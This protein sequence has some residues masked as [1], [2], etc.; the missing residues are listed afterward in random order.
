MLGDQR[1]HA[2]KGSGG[3]RTGRKGSVTSSPASRSASQKTAFFKTVP[4]VTQG[5]DAHQAAALRPP[6]PLPSR[7]R[8][9]PAA[10]IGLRADGD[11]AL[12]FDPAARLRLDARLAFCLSSLLL[13]T[14]LV[15]GRLVLIHAIPGE[16][17]LASGLLADL[18]MAT[19]LLLLA[20]LLQGL[21][22]AASAA[23]IF[24]GLLLHLA[25]LEMA[26]AMNTYV[27]L[28]DLRF[29]ADE[30]FLQGSLHL[31]FPVYSAFLAASAVLLLIASARLG[32]TGPV[33]RHALAAL[34]AAAV[35]GVHLLSGRV[36]R[37]QLA[38]MSWLSLTRSLQAMLAT[39]GT[40]PRPGQT[41]AAFA[42]GSEEG[43]PLLQ[44]TPGARRNVL[45]VVLEGIPGAYLRQVQ[46][47]AGLGGAVQMPHLSRIAER[48]LVVPNFAA[49]NRQTI[50]GLY[51]L[52]SGDYCKLSLATPKIYDYMNLPA[53]AREPCL[54]S[55]LASRGYATGYLQ[56]AELAYM[57]K[58]RFMSA[59]GFKQVLGKKYFRY[60]HV[61]FYWGPDDK[62]FF[63]QAAEFIV[64]M[65]ASSWTESG[66]IFHYPTKTI[67]NF[68]AP[69]A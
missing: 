2:D 11:S 19:C 12:D 57:S 55:T 45:I 49:H 61:P 35:L 68:H 10:S 33:P 15:V 31:S 41:M 16:R 66:K 6:R 39:A 5:R 22:L 28:P 14:V 42:A 1:A 9:P 4:I 21:H 34:L 50:R 64:P 37:W 20:R 59:A 30:R 7:C 56:A 43:Q 62:A 60:Q 46:Q 38:S 24:L 32:P 26:A 23:V 13:A 3:G 27:F 58:D 8:P 36:D 67:Q 18:A 53:Q 63:E 25:N 47:H 48:S 44:R 69:S 52:L 17:L 65:C 51:S 40:A 54:P 29:A